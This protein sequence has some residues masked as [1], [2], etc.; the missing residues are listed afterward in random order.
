MR[1]ES[2]VRRRTASRH[3]LPLQAPTSA[4]TDANQEIKL[5]TIPL[6][7]SRVRAQ[8]ASVVA[9]GLFFLLSLTTWI[10]PLS[11]THAQ[12]E[13]PDAPAA[14]GRIVYTRQD[15]ADSTAFDMFTSDPDGSNEL[16][17][18][19]INESL[20]GEFQP[21]WSPD[22]TKVVFATGDRTTGI[23]SLWIIDHQG[24]EPE[25]VVENDGRGKDPSWSP[26]GK[27]FAFSG[28]HGVGAAADH[29]R[30]DIKV[31]CEDDGVAT[32]TDTP[33]IDERDPEWSPDG[34]RILYVARHVDSPDERTMS[35]SMH[36]IGIEDAEPTLLLD[37]WGSN[38]RVPRWSPDGQQIAFIVSDNSE[39]VFGTLHLLAPSSGEISAV[40][41]KPA[42][43]ITWS[44]D[45]DGIVFSNVDDA[46]ITR[47]GDEAVSEYARFSELLD[48]SATQNKGLYL[49]DLVERTVSR[50]TGYAGGRD[51]DDFQYG[52][53]PDWTAGTA[54]PTPI[55][56]ATF[57]PSPTSEAT[58]TSSTP[59]I[60]PTRTSSATPTGEAR[61]PTLI[62][63]PY[64]ETRGS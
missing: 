57:T 8:S 54:T 34:E 25:R 29:D 51:M 35:W 40:L 22:G 18:S 43:S 36:T 10:G 62:H 6:S 55:A 17:L 49:F 45:S 61:P 56:T 27:C 9:S 44:P 64:A 33:D 39:W 32:I 38:E 52:Y 60:R 46:G 20:A 1:H 3:H 59:T 5:M 53:A 2:R 47:L 24:G 63:I 12:D 7:S 41:R 58:N 16:K 26:D 50:L 37:W 30:F 42:A 4:P 31:W 19:T 28:A 13:I 21:R 15:S 14:P 23:A 48:M 11:P